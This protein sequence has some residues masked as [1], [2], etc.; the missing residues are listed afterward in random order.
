MQQYSEIL[1]TDLVK[2]SRSKINNNIMTVASHYSGTVFPTDNL[3]DGMMCYRK[4]RKELYMYVVDENDE[5]QW[6][7]LF[8]F[9]ASNEVVVVN[10]TNSEFVEHE[11]KVYLPDGSQLWVE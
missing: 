5:G 9:N 2:N 6:L 3:T 7:L 10:A 1:G 4:D 8:K 11:G